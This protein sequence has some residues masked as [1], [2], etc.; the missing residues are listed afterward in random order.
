M[1]IDNT[2]E[3]TVK[4]QDSGVHV[5]TITQYGCRYPDGTVKWV[6]DSYTGTWGHQSIDFA[7]YH[8]ADNSDS[9]R[10]ARRRWADLME[11][12]AKEA[13]IDPY[14]YAKMHQFIK[15]TIIISISEVEDIADPV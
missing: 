3:F 15:R 11:V 13:K 12:R 6:N 10:R 4:A 1:T 5:D 7:K 8:N 14:T 9:H 2:T